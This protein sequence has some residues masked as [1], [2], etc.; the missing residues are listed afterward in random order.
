M[1]AIFRAQ[2]KQF[3][4]EP[5]LRLKIP[6]LDAEP[7]DRVTFDEVLLAEKDG[8]VRVGTP[9]LD[10]A[11][12][13]AEIVGHGKGD[14]I[15]VYKMKRRKGY[16]R[17]QGHRQGYTEIR[18]VEISFPKGRK[19]GAAKA[20]P[21]PAEEPAAEAPKAKA[22][23]PKAEA[24]P[25]PAVEKTPGEQP[26]AEAAAVELDIT[27]A[28]AELAAEHGI[29]LATIEGTGKDGRILKSD[30]DRAIKEKDA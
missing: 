23:K 16:R 7:G 17:K 13:A 9:S 22:E 14:K 12:V 24:A 3:R 15:I 20:E 29:D 4:A 21:K 6:T 1:Y 30:I 5:D 19:K 2:G 28:A 25:E 26:V 27:P 11:A 10:G 18:I 8:E